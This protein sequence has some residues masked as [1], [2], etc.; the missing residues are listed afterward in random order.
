MS[1]SARVRLEAAAAFVAGWPA[2]TELVVVGATRE[3]ADDFCRG[4][5]AAP[6]RDLRPAPL[7]ARPARLADR[8]GD[9]GGARAGAGDGA[10]RRRA[11]DPRA[12]RA[13]PRRD[14]RLPGAGRRQP[15]P[16]ARAG[17]H[18][19]RAA[20]G[21]RRPGAL[22]RPAAPPGR[23]SARLG[24]RYAALLGRGRARRSRGAPRRRRPRACA[25]ATPAACRPGR[26]SC[27]TCRIATA[28]ERDVRRRAGRAGR[29]GRSRR[30]RPVTS[31]TLRAAAARR[32][33][34]RST[35]RDDAGSRRARPR[36]RASCSRRGAGRRRGRQRP[37]LLGAGRSAARRSRSRGGSSTRRRAACRSTRWRSSC[38]RPRAYWGP[39]EQ[40]LERAEVPA[41][42]S[43]GTRRPDP[44]GRAFLALLA[45]AADGLSARRFAE[46]LSL[47]QV[48]RRDATG[49]PAP[50][51][52]RSSSRA[53]RRSRRG[54]L[55]LLDVARRAR[56]RPG[57]R[58]AAPA[59][60]PA[61]ILR[62]SGRDVRAPWRWESLLVDAAVASGPDRRAAPSAGGGGSTA[63]AQE[64]ALRLR[65]LESD[66][67]DAAQVA[68]IDAR[69]R[70][71]RRPAP[72]RAAAHRRAG[73]A[74]ARGALGR[75]ARSPRAR[76]RRARC[77]IRRASSSC[78]PSCG[79]WRAVGPVT[80]AEVRRVLL[81]RLP[82]LEREPPK[83][84]FGR[85]FVG[86]PDAAARPHASA[87]CSSSASPSASS[88]SAAARI[89]CCSTR[90]AARST[91][92][93]PSRTIASPPSALLLRLAVGA[94]TRALL[95]LVSAARRRR[96]ARPRVP[97]FYALDVVRAVDAA[98]CPTTM[99]FERDTAIATGAW[100]AWPAPDDPATA[101][102]RRGSTTWPCS[103]RLLRRRRRRRR[104]RARAHYLLVAERARSRARCATR[105]ARWKRSWSTL[106]RADRQ[107]ATRAGAARR[108]APDG[109]ALLG[110]GA[111]ALL[112]LPVPVPARRD[113][114]PRAA[115]A[116]RAP[117]VQLD[118]LTR[119]AH[120]P[121][122]PARRAARA[123]PPTA[124]CRSRRSAAA[125]RSAILDATSRR[126]HSRAITI[127]SR[128]RS[129][130]SG[131]TRST[132]M[133]GRPAPV[134]R[135]SVATASAE[136]VPRYFELS[137]GLPIDDGARRGER[138]A[139][140]SC[141]TG[142]SRCA[143][144]S[145]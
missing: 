63:C 67:P 134:A 16:A 10:G 74:A 92:H 143:A 7:H 68:A 66:E 99:R 138:A 82:T 137:F 56:G 129:S 144:R 38:A 48:P 111:A 28:A 126:G 64:L 15:R 32:S 93:W 139:S 72:L 80:L 78:S 20:R 1:A 3:A 90:C 59:T 94:A 29:R 116:A 23:T 26:S 77:G 123:A 33:R 89:R 127:A 87:S 34:R 135:R 105:W 101:H 45:C 27:S 103:A 25:P 11:R 60:E 54:Q 117:I 62:P 96:R 61:A 98:T 79:R 42:F 108:P 24:D 14:A 6:R 51:R 140:R 85:V 97:S 35:R 58:A 91:R 88:R 107:H 52:R 76:W 41:W 102:R 119:G 57:P 40:A 132:L 18:A 84:R 106:R 95:A 81:P 83:S 53:T 122:D 121:R 5:A 69:P 17:R 50:S 31:R 30:S 2:S 109:A 55:S 8:H 13:A 19:G 113:L 131:R 4:L 145:T 73:G 43:R 36:P 75:L 39:L 125:R 46:Y 71:A 12:L 142:A 110:V 104:P 128:R 112:G 136:W 130:A 70:R 21:R 114:P 86:T 37:V 133:R 124:C 49:A 100:L 22:A 65:E 115:R 118:P 120:L 141:S 9:P 47:G 44:T